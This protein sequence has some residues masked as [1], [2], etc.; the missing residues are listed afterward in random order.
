MKFFY[1][2]LVLTMKILI[3]IGDAVL[4]TITKIHK[5]TFIWGRKINK[6]LSKLLQNIKKTL[7]FTP[8]KIRLPKIQLPKFEI[9]IPTIKIKKRVKEV[10]VFKAPSRKTLSFSFSL[11][12]FHLPAFRPSL[13]SEAGRHGLPTPLFKLPKIPRLKLRKRARGRPRK[14]LKIPSTARLKYITF[15]GLFTF[16]FIFLPLLLAIFIQ[17]LPNPRELISQ[18]IAQ[19]TKIYDRNGILLYQLFADQD[20]T[21][22]P[23]SEIPKNLI[24]ATVAIEDKNFYS[25]TLGFDPLAILRS[26]IADLSGK[27]LQGGSTITQ[28][29]IKSRLLTPQQSLDRKIKEV[30]LAF[31]A[32]RIYTQNQILEMYLNQVPYG[33]TSWGAEAASQTY[34]G[35]S[36][37]Q[38]D[39]AQSAFLAG[40]PQA[41]SAYSPYTSGEVFW[42]KRQG[43]VLSKMASLGYITAEEARIAG[44]QKLTFQPAQHVLH[45]PHFV[46]YVKESLVKKYGLP[47]VERGG[48]SVVTS[49]DL[50]KQEMAQ[51]SVKK[52]VDK[53]GY[54]NIHNGAALITNPKNGDILAM[55]GGRD[56][57]DPDGG[58]FNVTTALRQPGSTIKVVT[59]SQALL[60]GYTA[61]TPIIDSPVAFASAGS[62]PYAPVNYDGKFHGTLTL[63]SAL[64]NSV[65]VPAVKT[66]NSVG[67]DKMMNLAKQMGITTWQDPSNYGLAITL[68]AA[69]VKMTDLATVYGTL[70]NQGK[71]VDLN[72]ILKITDYQGNVLEEK[73]QIQEIEILP[74][75]IA[76]II[77][78][79]LSDNSARAM[80]FGPSSTLNIPGHTVS[81]KTGTTD[82]KRD[83]W[84][85]GFTPSYL[86]SVWVGNNNNTPLNPTL[87]SGITGA[88][89]IWHDIMTNI[90][91]DSSKNDENYTIPEDIVTRPCFGRNEY[92]VRGTENSVNCRFIPQTSP[93]PSASP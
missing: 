29:L 91:K 56:Y 3:T 47:L 69:E 27:P 1:D 81:V 53:S 68:G 57:Y 58:N 80:A 2:L 76:F 40:L 55:I 66:L 7:I 73:S 72:P 46:M 70:A 5:E 28:Q 14:P 59:Y 31:W 26:L 41:P 90:L 75:S 38:L 4:L 18:D 89:P 52:E 78:N 25:S 15:G 50:K 21:L 44:N 82:N 74:R 61:A 16:F 20:R 39:L 43:D 17:S 93:K 77:S 37:I 49:L 35:K 11:P 33:G 54:L 87:A 83:N 84:T 92:F 24:N 65:N 63:R 34:F 32:Q 45:A 30:V 12:S 62:P 67:I 85:I 51:D 8:P 23:L 88:A 64:G 22:I 60:N 10:E 9:K 36:A 42:K 19:S 13:Q 71:R 79:I 6:T 48:L 86:V